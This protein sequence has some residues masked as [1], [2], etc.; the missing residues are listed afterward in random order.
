MT[1]NREPPWLCHSCGYMMDANSAL[2]G[3]AMPKENDV[4]M[5]LNCGALYTRHSNKWSPMTLAERESLEP[6]ARRELAA[7]QVFRGHFITTDLSKR[8]SKT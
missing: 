7:M 5:C 6:Q 1:A 4:S 8:D 3:Q 2:D